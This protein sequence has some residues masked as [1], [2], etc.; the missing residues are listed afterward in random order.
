M[1][2]DEH[3]ARVQEVF[4][5]YWGRRLEDILLTTNHVISETVTLLRKRGHPDPRVRHRLAVEVG[6]QLFAGT[7][8]RVYWTSE[9]EERAAFG[10]FRK[11]QDQV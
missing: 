9:D 5:G 10:Y 8:G 2:G 3:H 4:E 7:L 1:E 11:H 6:E